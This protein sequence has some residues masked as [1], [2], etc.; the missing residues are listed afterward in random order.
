MNA[1]FAKTETIGDQEILELAGELRT[2]RRKR[3]KRD[4]RDR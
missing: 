2:A 4:G 1:K 3:F